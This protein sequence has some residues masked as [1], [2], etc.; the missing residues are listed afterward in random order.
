M[1][2]AY[3]EEFHSAGLGLDDDGS[4]R[5][6][7]YNPKWKAVY[8]REAN[9]ILG[10]VVSTGARLYH[11]GSTSVPGI[12]AK[13]ILDV[14]MAVSSLENLDAVKG[15]I[16]QLGYQARGEYGLEGRR[17][18]VLKK[19]GKT[20]VHLHC[21][22][23]ERVEILRH[24]IFRS[25]LQ[26][27]PEMAKKYDAVKLEVLRQTGLSRSAYQDSKAPI[28]DEIMAKA[29]QWA[30]SPEARTLCSHEWVVDGGV[31]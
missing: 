3:L 30:T 1:T 20:Y 27:N 21:W 15:K 17:Y 8:E 26:H 13:P 22:Q 23:E 4:F 14:L 16:E 5:I 9:R 12:H 19:E 24:I 11:V 29:Q 6:A 25:Y 10:A 18:F 28:I 7:F 31:K 2:N